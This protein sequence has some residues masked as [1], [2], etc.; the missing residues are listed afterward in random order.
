MASASIAESLTSV[1]FLKKT[2]SVLS[3]TMCFIAYFVH[4]QR[5][6]DR[7]A[8]QSLKTL[9]FIAFFYQSEPNLYKPIV[10]YYIFRTKSEPSE[11]RQSAERIPGA[12]QKSAH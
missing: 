2:S 3:K 9:I 6:K 4:F 10:F 1:V 11:C 12:D 5:P 7:R 8:S